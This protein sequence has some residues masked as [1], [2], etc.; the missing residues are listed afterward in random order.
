MERT[1]PAPLA[2]DEILYPESDGLPMVEN[3]KQYD[4]LTTIKGN[5][6]I[7]NADQPHVF[8]AG[9]LFWYPVEGHPE[10]RL[11]PDVMVV[12]GWPKGHRGA[13]MQWREGNIPPQIIFEIL[14][15]GNTVVEMNRKF[16]FYDQ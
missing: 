6:D 13:Y 9:D 1:Y 11:A 15:P 4:P 8:V 14:S 7:L 16:R 10:I 12:F 3:T 5:L 2:Q